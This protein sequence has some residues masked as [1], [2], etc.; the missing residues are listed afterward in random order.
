MASLGVAEAAIVLAP[1]ED[2]T[3]GVTELAE[4]SFFSRAR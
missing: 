1:G 3:T 4:V 2:V